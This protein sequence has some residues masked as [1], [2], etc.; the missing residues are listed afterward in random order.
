MTRAPHRSLLRVAAVLVSLLPLSSAG[1]SAPRDLL[2]DVVALPSVSLYVGGPASHFVNSHGDVVWGCHPSEVANDTPTPARCLRFQTIA[3]NLGAG[4]LELHYRADQIAGERGVVQRLYSSDG[5]YRDV[6]AG[7]YVLD[8]THAHFHYT[9][10][11][12]ASLWRSDARGRRLGG[13]P[14][15]A[16]RKAGFCL[17]DVYR[18]RSGGSQTYVPPQA[19]YP[20]H[21]DG[22]E[23][24]QV[25]GVSVGWADVYDMA[26]PHQYIEITGVPDG[27]YLLQITV[28]PL[29]KLRETTTRDNTVWQRIRLCGDAA[30]IVG[31]SNQCG[32]GAA[33]ATPVP[34]TPS[35]AHLEDRLAY[36]A[37]RP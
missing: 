3:A 6:G 33:V 5:R 29:H 34:F 10:F 19:C 16:G 18:Y 20:S 17:E 7:S 30:D 1:A 2:P 11:A 24:S 21:A 15:R 36:C 23:V 8:P 14:V 27:Y 25:N 31:R 35:L 32:G 9:D 13:V 22:G 28:D 37:L 12:V 26:V 4:P